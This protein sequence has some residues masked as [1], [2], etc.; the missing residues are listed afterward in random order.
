[1]GDPRT[2]EERY[3][4]EYGNVEDWSAQEC[5]HALRDMIVSLDARLAALIGDDGNG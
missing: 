5:M 4:A 3:D 1:M 2:P